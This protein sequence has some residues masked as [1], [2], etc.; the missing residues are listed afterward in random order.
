MAM[1]AAQRNAVAK[2]LTLA[3]AARVERRRFG[4]YTVES[5]TRTGAAYAVTGTAPDGSDLRCTCPASLAGRP[6]WHAALIWVLRLR[7]QGVRVTGPAT[8]DSPGR[9]AASRAHQASVA[10]GAEEGNLRLPARPRSPRREVAL[11][12]RAA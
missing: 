10:R 2:A 1:T 9:L 8:E 7:S 11:L 3:G 5:A 4:F 6:C 12:E